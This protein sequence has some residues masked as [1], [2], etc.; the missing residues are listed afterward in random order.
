MK[1]RILLAAFALVAVFSLDVKPAKAQ[2][3]DG[4]KW[5]SLE[6]AEKLNANKKTKKKIF[7]DVYTEWCGWCKRLDATTY[8]D[9]DVVK[10]VN[11]NFYAV[12]LDAETKD[13]VNFKGVKHAYDPARRTN[14]VASYFMPPSGGGYPTLTYLD[15]EFKVVRIA[16]GYVSKDDL[17]KQLHYVNDNYYLNMSY[18][19]YM[20]QAAKAPEGK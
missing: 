8:K 13:T 4:I 14:T 19:K 1:L 17:L 7:V 6:Q 20:A 10:Y 16:P 15:D 5:I 12:K 18:E 3:K 11:D 9:P 2:D